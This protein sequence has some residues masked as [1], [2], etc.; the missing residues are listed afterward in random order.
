M[1]KMSDLH[2]YI[3]ELMDEDLTYEDIVKRIMSE[4]DMS[5]EYA[6]NM[7]LD[8]Y[9]EETQDDD[10]DSGSDGD[11][12]ASAGWGTDEDYGHFDDYNYDY[13]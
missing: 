5:Q 1:S 12:L 13:D 6:E 7:I 4:Y 9:T 11:A 8:V 2:L 10:F 3:K